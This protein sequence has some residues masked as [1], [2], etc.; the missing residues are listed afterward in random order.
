MANAEKS[1]LGMV[2]IAAL[3]DHADVGC[4]VTGNGSVVTGGAPQSVDISMY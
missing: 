2:A 4:G 1:K 3:E